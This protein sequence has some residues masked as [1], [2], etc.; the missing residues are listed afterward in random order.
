MDF[1][2]NYE[3]YTI[4]SVIG[5]LLVFVI[6]LAKYYFT[7]VDLNLPMAYSSISLSL[8]SVGTGCYLFAAFMASNAFSRMYLYVRTLSS[9]KLEVFHVSSYIAYLSLLGGLFYLSYS[10]FGLLPYASIEL[11]AVSAFVVT[12]YVFLKHNKNTYLKYLGFIAY[13]I[14]NGV[15]LYWVLLM[16]QYI[17]ASAIVVFFIDK[18][19]VMREKYFTQG[20]EIKLNGLAF[21]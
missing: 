7:K 13:A 8:F 16:N 10:V 21:I 5:G 18:V 9:K 17:F 12:V 14:S 6:L 19:L 15:I 2:Y 3:P 4:L 1:I 20:K 11:Y